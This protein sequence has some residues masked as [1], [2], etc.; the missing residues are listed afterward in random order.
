M[1]CKFRP[2][3]PRPKGK[4]LSLVQK[5]HKPLSVPQ[6]RPPKAPI[7]I[8]QLELI[9]R[10]AYAK[11]RDLIKSEYEREG[12]QFYDKYQDWKLYQ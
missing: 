12:R 11:S 6:T 8:G 3:L 5:V 10:R 1:M 7:T 9:A 2:R 4:R